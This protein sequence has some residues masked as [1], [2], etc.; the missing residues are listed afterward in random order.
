MDKF[1]ITSFFKSDAINL[2]EMINDILSAYLKNV[3]E[4]PY[5]D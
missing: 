4:G 1:K 5:N 2:Q 3:L